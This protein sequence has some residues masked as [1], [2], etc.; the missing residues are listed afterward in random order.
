MCLWEAQL[1]VPVMVLVVILCAV[2]ITA[3]H[4]VAP[5]WLGG[6]IRALYPSSLLIL[7]A[8]CGSRSVSLSDDMEAPGHYAIRVT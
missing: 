7:T 6:V 1:R 4:W 3:T 5:I 8:R 2:K